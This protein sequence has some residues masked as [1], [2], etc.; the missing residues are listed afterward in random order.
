LTAAPSPVA[1]VGDPVSQNRTAGEFTGVS[2][3]AGINVVLAVGPATRVTVTAQP[4]LLPLVTTTVS[5]G[6]LVADIVSPGISS[7]RPVTVRVTAPAITSVSLTGGAAGTM[8]LSADRL[9]IDASGGATIQAI[10]TVKQLSLSASGGAAAQLGSLVATLCKVALDGGSKATLNVKTELTGT[11]GAG[12]T[13]TLVTKP[14]AQSV[15][16]SGGA[17][18]TGP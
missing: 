1:G 8:E 16:L 9:D 15:T 5:G 11:A 18:I 4:N 14:T 13:I 12:A 6:R 10:G 2:A 7:T 17:T 3:G